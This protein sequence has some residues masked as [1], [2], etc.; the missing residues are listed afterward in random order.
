MS[1]AEGTQTSEISTE[2]GIQVA[3]PAGNEGVSTVVDPM[4]EQP[5]GEKPAEDQP[6][7][8]EPKA[9]GAPES[10]ADFTLP[11]GMVMHEDSLNSFT[12]IAKA[13]GLSQEAAQKYIDLASGLVQQTQD[14]IAQAEAKA[15]EEKVNGWYKESVADKEFGG[16][17]L[18]ESLTKANSVLGKYGSPELVKEFKEAGLDNYPG[19]IRMLSKIGQDMLPDEVLTGAAT[20]GAPKSA[21][22][23]LFPG[24][25]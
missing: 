20:E 8:E 23:V 6:K 2:P 16:D 3:N 13:D 5:E 22:Q 25:K 18:K 4:L 1:E 11:E 24:F 19:L 12:E 15:K 21:A 7:A 17:K 14:G 10:Y 9:E